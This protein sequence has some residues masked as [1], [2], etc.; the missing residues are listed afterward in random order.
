LSI[1]QCGQEVLERTAYTIDAVS[2]DLLMG[3]EVGFPA[4]GRTINADGLIKSSGIRR[5]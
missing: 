4:N 5:L 2:G 1:S 3:L